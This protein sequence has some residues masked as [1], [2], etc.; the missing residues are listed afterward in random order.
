MGFFCGR[1]VAMTMSAGLVRI[2][3]AWFRTFVCCNHQQIFSPLKKQSTEEVSN[4]GYGLPGYQYE[5]RF[6]KVML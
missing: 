5:R 6:S 2:E 1:T 3:D 4:F